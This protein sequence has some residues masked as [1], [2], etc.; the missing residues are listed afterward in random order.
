MQGARVLHG[1]RAGEKHGCKGSN[2]CAGNVRELTKAEC[3]GIKGNGHRRQVAVRAR[4]P[5]ARARRVRRTLVAGRMPPMQAVWMRARLSLALAL[6]LAAC[7]STSGPTTGDARDASSDA[8]TGVAHD[9]SG[10]ARKGVAHDA[11][12]DAG[13]GAPADAGADGRAAANDSGLPLADE[14]C[15]AFDIPLASLTAHNTSASP[16]YEASSSA[17]AAN[18]GTTSTVS[19][20]GAT[21]TISPAA[22]DMSMNPVTP[23]HVSHT[24]VHTLVPSR[25]D[26]RWFAHI[27]PWFG[28]SSHV[29]IGVNY[30]TAAY[31]QAMVTDMKSRG[32]DGVIIDWYGQ[33]S[34]E[35]SVTLKLR[36]Y[37]DTLPAKSFTFIIMMDKGIVSGLS[38]A[39]GRRRWRRR[40]RTSSRAEGLPTSATRT[41]SSRGKP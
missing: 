29:D 35:D 36:T 8:R 4:A 9:A 18:F 17:V 15:S 2:K 27:T 26:L 40:L 16:D 21:V 20:A 7:S 1:D 41:T 10:D 31:V 14:A 25:P 38:A 23:G 3:D 39:A 30:D 37:L 5:R 34:F 6:C 11:T 12:S 32:F 24:D 19:Q 28:S 22:M 13:I 33:G